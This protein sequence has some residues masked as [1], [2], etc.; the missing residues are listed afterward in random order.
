MANGF[1]QFFRTIGL[2][3]G[4]ALLAACDQTVGFGGASTRAVDARNPVNVALLVPLESGQSELDFLAS[5][6]V[7]AAN[8]A[9]NDMADV[10]LNIRVYPTGGDP[11]RAQAAATRAV[12]EGAQVFVGPLFSTAAAAVAPVAA[13][14]GISV[15]SFSNNSQ[16]AGN[17]VY[18]LGLTFDSKA[19]RVVSHAIARGQR[20]IAVIHSADP[21]GRSGLSAASNAIAQFGGQFAGAFPYELSPQG[22]STEAPNIAR[23]VNASGASAVVLTDDPGAGLVFLTPVLASAGLS[24]KSVQFLGLTNW[25]T[26]AEAAATPSMQGGIFAAPDPSVYGQFV[27]RYTSTYGASPH[28]LAGLAYDGIAAVGAMVQ[29]ARASGGGALTRA[30]ITDPTGFAGVNGVFRFR[31]DGGNDRGLALVQLRDGQ[32]TVIGRAPRNFGGAGS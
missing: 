18:L 19:R 21:A 5:S 14:N 3:F 10:P 31:Q 24:S 11:G 25:D 30:Q 15:L 26:P 32:P 28:N 13:Q 6:L 12:S 27:N 20:D 9:N 4:I 16:V 17:N 8:M 2:V 1:F 22:I 23:Q 7:N 29:S